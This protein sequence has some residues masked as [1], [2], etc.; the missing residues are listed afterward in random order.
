MLFTITRRRAGL[1]CSGPSPSPQGPLLSS[2]TNLRT[3]HKRILPGRA[4]K[5]QAP[6]GNLSFVHQQFGQNPEPALPPQPQPEGCAIM[7]ERPSPRIITPAAGC[8]TE[9][10]F[11]LRECPSDLQSPPRPRHRERPRLSCRPHLN[12]AG[13]PRSSRSMTAPRPTDRR[14]RPYLCQN[15]PRVAPIRQPRQGL[16]C[17]QRHPPLLREVVDVH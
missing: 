15:P 2:R 11:V 8:E 9:R 7:S 12:A 3:Q 6:C 14:N 16:Q 4:C 17:A 1:N 13:A 5:K 10:G